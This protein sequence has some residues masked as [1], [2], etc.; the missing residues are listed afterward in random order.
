MR[1]QFACLMY[2]K[3]KNWK[4][5]QPLLKKIHQQKRIKFKFFYY[6]LQFIKAYQFLKLNEEERH[7]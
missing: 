4:K 7:T 5:S 3:M 2:L 1:N 6:Q